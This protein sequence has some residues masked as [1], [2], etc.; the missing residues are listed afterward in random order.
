MPPWIFGWSV[1]TRPSS[2]SG[3]PVTSATSRT[4]TPA[5]RKSLAVPP[6]ETISIPSAPRARANSTTPVLSWTETRARRT[7][8]GCSFTGDHPATVDRQPSF[9]EEADGVGIQAVL[10]RQDASRQGLLG[11]VGMH[12]HSRLQDDRPG[13]HA[14]VDE[15]HGGAGDS[16]P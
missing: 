1:L 13:V 10:L 12:G 6:V 15:V 9:G 11:V 7:F 16:D 2:I 14:L 3:K 8:T 5:S 4:G